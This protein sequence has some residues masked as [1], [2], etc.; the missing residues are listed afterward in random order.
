MLIIVRHKDQNKQARSLVRQKDQNKQ[1]RSLVRH[2]DQ[3]KQARST[4]IA[5]RS[6]DFRIVF[7]DFIA[8]TNY[9]ILH[10]YNIHV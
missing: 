2:K 10:K 6:Y 5:S 1:A 8:I 4:A 9:I 3:N 7:I